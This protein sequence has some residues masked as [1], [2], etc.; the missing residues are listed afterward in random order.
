[1]TPSK[2]SAVIAAF[3]QRFAKTGRA[4]ARFHRYLIDGHSSRNVGDYDTGPGLSADDAATQ[5]TRAEEFL[6]LA[7]QLL[8]PTSPQE[9]T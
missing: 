9:E 5:N 8:G 7:D 3:G 6:K 1:M 4:P 2:H